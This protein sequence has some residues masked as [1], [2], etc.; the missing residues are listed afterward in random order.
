[1]TLRIALATVVLLVLMA[2]GALFIWYMAYGV[3]ST[4]DEQHIPVSVTVADVPTALSELGRQHAQYRTWPTLLLRQV[5]M[6]RLSD[7]YMEAG[8]AVDARIIQLGFAET[9]RVSAQ[10]LAPEHASLLRAYVDGVNEALAGDKV[11]LHAPVVLLDISPEPWQP[12]HSLAVERL[13]LWLQEPALTE[14]DSLLQAVLGWSGGLDNAAWSHPDGSVTSRI[15]TGSSA[16]PVLMESEFRLP[17][18]PVSAITIPGTPMMPTGRMNG[19]TWAVLMRPD[20]RRI[21]A[22][23]APVITHRRLSVN[24]A[25]RLVQR[26]RRE[27]RPDVMPTPT[28]DVSWTGFTEGTDLPRWLELWQGRPADALTGHWSLM[29]PDGMLVVDGSE[30]AFTGTPFTAIRSRGWAYASS[31]PPT[32]GPVG[33]LA[34]PPAARSALVSA[35]ARDALPPFLAAIPDSLYRSEAAG[36]ALTYLRN[37]NYSFDGPEIGAT[38]YDGISRLPDDRT[39]LER[40]ERT[41]GDLRR[42][43]GADMSRWQWAD[44]YPATLAMPGTVPSSPGMHR[45]LRAFLERYAPVERRQAGHPTTLRWHHTREH[46]ATSVW[47]G[48]LHPDGQLDVSRPDVDYDRFLGRTVTQDPQ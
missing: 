5:A 15:L 11:R 3:G 14:A 42:R 8:A 30:P 4:P 9:A 40:L 48:T 31:R 38:L 10:G 45:P 13:V 16:I 7:W 39:P 24:G 21:A 41:V 44:R 47:E 6:G 1:M 37:W 46:P 20:V 29:R 2:F 25:E 36:Q 22:D 33:I 34:D 43:L 35:V 23:G 17:R 27:G 28:G 32:E 12:W 19:S 26:D 18:G